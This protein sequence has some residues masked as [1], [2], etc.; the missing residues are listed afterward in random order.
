MM[1]RVCTRRKFI[2]ATASAS[3]LLLGAGML[4][5]SCDAKK[6][7]DEAEV[8][9]GSVDSCDDLSGVSA[10]ELEK[11]EKLG[12][13]NQTPIPENRCDNCKL[14]LPAGEDKP[15]GGCMLFK[16]PVYASGYCTYWAPQV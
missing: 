12:Y 2:T 13:V 9:G 6:T 8:G 7:S 15:C 1:K 16:G 3:P 14:Y 5:G 4:M 11:R 10:A